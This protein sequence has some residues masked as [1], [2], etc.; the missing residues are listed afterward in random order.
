MGKIVIDQRTIDVGAIRSDAS[1]VITGGV[2]G[3]GL[4][5]AKWLVERGARHLLLLSRKG[6]GEKAREAIRKLEEAGARVVVASG[7]VAS[8]ADLQH[9]LTLS[10]SDHPV[11]GII[12]A[13]GVID[14]ATLQ[15]QD[16]RRFAGVLVPKV[17]GSW[18]LHRLTEKMDLD[19]FVMCSSA[20]AVFGT[21]GQGNYA[22][23]NA[24]MDGLAGHRRFLGLPALSINWGPWSDVGM[25]ANVS[26]KDKNRWDALGVGRIAPEDG[27]EA[28]EL[29]LGADDTQVAVLPID[30]KT[31]LRQAPSGQE[32]CFLSAIVHELQDSNDNRTIA[33]DNNDFMQRVREVHEED[34]RQLVLE[35]VKEQLIHVF[36]LKARTDIDDN[37][38]FGDLG[39]DSLMAVEISNRLK[40]SFGCSLSST[41]AFEYSTLNRLTDYVLL[42]VLKNEFHQGENDMRSEALT[43]LNRIDDLSDDQVNELL[44]KISVENGE[45]N[46][47]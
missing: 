29:A 18:N 30:W 25:A 14:D 7:D 1:Y 34:R 17:H 38:E 36:G 12:H 31:Y 2:G 37:Q 46:I 24:F 3:L 9:L 27:P 40:R 13:A 5:F 16:R 23:A 47:G 8:R 32:P 22:A 11:K 10:G 4:S 21:P 20:A 44:N 35:H 15:N 6:A 33:R 41:I 26:E 43:L 42:V 39:M 45:K 19:F 28:L